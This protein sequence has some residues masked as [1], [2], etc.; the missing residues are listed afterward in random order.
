M[1][2][3]F[4][5]HKSNI[6]R[7][8][9]SLIVGAIAICGSSANA[10]PLSND[11]NS[12]FSNWQQL[13][14]VL[15]Q[16]NSEP[17]EVI[18]DP[19]SN[20]RGNAGNRNPDSNRPTTTTSSDTRFTC[21]YIDGEYTVMYYPETQDN[22]SYPWAIPSQL[23]GGW[24][25]ERRCNEIATRLES[26]RGDGLLEM[27]TGVENGY[28]T[29]CVTTQIDPTDC[30]IVL[31]VPPNQDPQI[32]RDLVFENLL[33]ADDGQQTQGVYTYGENGGSDDIIGDIGNV[34]GVVKPQQSPDKI[35]LRPFL[36]PTD[37]GT[38]AQL[39]NNTAPSRPS[40]SSNNERKPSIFQ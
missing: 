22:S 26:Y 28:D 39:K 38:G 32:T 17:P 12:S 30:R 6:S 34:L 40:G 16:R 10:A 13:R 27:S 7:T 24:T 9:T 14:Q 4:F 37:G 35:D 33:I 15:T 29:V 3:Q 21:D 25:P 36:A 5:K 23:G 1:S 18:I 20:N 31:T 8:T 11:S 19:D 2:F